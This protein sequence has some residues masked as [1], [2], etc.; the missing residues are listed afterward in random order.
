MDFSQTPCLPGAVQ[1][2]GELE[3]APEANALSKAASNSTDVCVVEDTFEKVIIPLRRALASERAALS[4]QLE[5]QHRTIM[6][7]VQHNLYMCLNTDA[8]S[9]GKQKI[10]PCDSTLYSAPPIVAPSNRQPSPDSEDEEA[11]PWGGSLPESSQRQLIG[12]G[13]RR[14]PG[15][16]VVDSA[17]TSVPLGPVRQST[18]STLSVP[19][20]HGS[21]LLPIPSNDVSA[22]PRLSQVSSNSAISNAMTAM[23]RPSQSFGFQSRDLSLPVPLKDN[24]QAE[25][26]RIVQ[27]LVGRVS[28]VHEMPGQF[29]Q[30][31]QAAGG[32]HHNHSH[33]DGMM[34]VECTWSR[35]QWSRIS[36]FGAG[37]TSDE[38]FN[39]VV[40]SRFKSGKFG[41]R[42]FRD[43]KETPV[44]LDVAISVVIILNV[45]VMA[46]EL[47]WEA[48]K[49]R[50]TLGW[51]ETETWVHAEPVFKVTDHVFN[52]I[53]VME[54]TL[55]LWILALEYFRI[56]MNQLD[57]T[58]VI[59]SSIQMYVLEP[60][61]I[62]SGGNLTLFRLLRFAR[63]ARIMKVLRT[64]LFTELRVLCKTCISSIGALIWSMVLL[65]LIITMGGL[66]LCSLLKDVIQNPSQD[67]DL[68]M[69]LFQHYGSS[70]RSIYTVFEITFAGNWPNYLRPLIEKVNA[71]YVVF[72]L[73]YITIVVFA[74]I[75]II[76]AIFLKKTLQAASSDAEMMVHETRSLTHTI[77]E[78]LAAVFQALNMNGDGMLT[79]ETFMLIVSNPDIKAWLATLELD[80]H[81]VRGLFALLQEGEGLLSYEKFL[82]GILRLKGQARSLD[83]ISIYYQCDRI[84]TCMALLNEKLD[85][86]S[87]G[88][89]DE[90]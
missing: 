5:Q 62:G 6:S 68:R 1:H 27:G 87:P 59:A 57:F 38:E 20:K 90:A 43:H 84:E 4:S 50:V 78:K 69:W 46:I 81:D 61:S 72:V 25:V 70:G 67:Q 65:F 75:R 21:L 24:D 26:A 36:T 60:L 7:D 48:D 13:Q 41:T 47:E 71:W 77:T 79:E 66:F 30:E 74:V 32:G 37:I 3:A 52:A 76:T 31:N 58:L 2:S 14:P 9:S 15:K 83:V 64:P 86:L 28:C 51:Q 56:H 85:Q 88:T 18:L 23:N 19:G 16:I 42:H 34:S 44:W 80:V 73:V 10:A 8:P 33:D 39:H 55:R 45:I 82:Q 40:A 29:G 12:A 22:L 89:G 54:T 63:L 49:S 53:Y 35:K 17:V 11:L